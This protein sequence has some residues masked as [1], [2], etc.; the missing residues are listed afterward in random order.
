MMYKYLMLLLVGGW[1]SVVSCERDTKNEP[2]TYIESNLPSHL[3]NYRM[4]W[5][6]EFDGSAVDMSKWNY[7]DEGNVRHYAVVSRRTISLDGEGHL[8]IKVIKDKDKY[9]VGQ[10]GTQG[11]FETTYG[12]F[13]CRAK[14][15]KQ[16]G[17]HVAF[18]LQSPDLGKTGDSAKDGAEID[19]FEYHR[20][21]PQ[22]VY[23]NIHW[24][25]YGA[26]HKQVGTQIHWNGVDSGFH[27]FGLEWDADKYVFYVDGKET[28]RT[29]SA[30]SKR[31]EYMI[32]STELTGWGGD[33]ALGT[34]PDEVI[35]DYVRVFKP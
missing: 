10:L 35:F 11:I 13:E 1:L 21:T 34:F 24:D 23:H 27:V 12:Y 5:H 7:R 3:E 14:M 2:P 22:I 26:N 25:G 19:I 33:P 8:S 17:P 29:S 30:V 4:V 6:D 9:Y 18:W 32:L 31:S 15:N 16:I 20:K 28:W